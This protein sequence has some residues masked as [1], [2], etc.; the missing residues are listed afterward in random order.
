MSITCDDSFKYNIEKLDSTSDEFKFI[1]G[2][3]ATTSKTNETMCSYIN[4]AYRNKDDF[5][6]YKVNEKNPIEAVDE[7]SNNLMLFHGTTKNGVTGILKDGFKNSER[8]WFGQGVY[9]TDSSYVA[10]MYS[11]ECY[12]SCKRNKSCFVIVNEIM[13]SEKLQIVEYDRIGTFREDIDTELK[14]PFNK[15]IS[16]SS[17]QLSKEDY[18][19]DLQGRQY[20]NVAVHRDSVRDEYVADESVTIPRYIIVVKQKREQKRKTLNQVINKLVFN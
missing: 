8:G 13:G 7:K 20:R 6:I 12:L 14:N 2:F 1:K 15:H 5:C 16:K 17:P 3:Y 11:N 19:E 9:L 4:I 18:K 10:R